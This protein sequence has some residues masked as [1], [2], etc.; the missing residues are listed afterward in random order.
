MRAFGCPVCGQLVFF[1]NSACLRCR[2]ELGFDPE[3][4]EVVGIDFARQARCANATAI[5]CNWLVPADR[6]GHRCTSCGLT[7]T[8]PNDADA[9]GLAAWAG[10]ESAK[11][12]LVHQLLDLGLPLEGLAFDLLSS[13]AGPVTTG[14]AAGVVTLDLAEADD[15][16]REQRRS[17]L[18]E[19]YR[20]V[21]GHLRHEVG[22]FYWDVLVDRGG[23]LDGFRERFGDERADYAEALER[24]YREGPPAAWQKRYVSA[25]ATAH[26]WEDWAETFA[27]VLHI[28]DTLQTAAAHG[29]KV[30]GPASAPIDPARSEHFV[31]EPGLDATGDELRVLLADWLPLTYALNA[32]NRSM[33]AHDLYPFV[34]AT[35]VIDKLTWAHELVRRP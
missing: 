3:R 21:L 13:R 7:R 16:R 20:T 31:A 22:H 15:G 9:E 12:R 5:G 2:T 27:H 14:H 1:E 4:L 26:P 10:V 25:Y 32:I 6:I 33:G 28:L 11:R 19:P 34:L 23:Q 30:A 24:H 35:T 18:G 17:E 8:R 29:V